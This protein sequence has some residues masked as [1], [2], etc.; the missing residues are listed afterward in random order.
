MISHFVYIIQSTVDITRYYV[1]YTTDPKARLKAHNEG[2]ST[3]T[4]KHKPWKL[5]T[6]I[7]F[8]EKAKAIAFEQYLKSHSGRAFCIKHF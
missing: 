5:V 6:I 1:G 7:G 3:Y 8:E 2:R 4:S